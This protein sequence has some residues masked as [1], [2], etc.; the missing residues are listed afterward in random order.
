[1]KIENTRLGEYKPNNIKDR[2]TDKKRETMD[3]IVV[4]GPNENED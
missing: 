1:M 3:Y 2:V 4:Y